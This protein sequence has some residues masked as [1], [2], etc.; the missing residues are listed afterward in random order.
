[1]EPVKSVVKTE[2]VFTAPDGIEHRQGFAAVTKNEAGEEISRSDI[3][4]PDQVMELATQFKADN[5]TF[6]EMR[7]E[8]TSVFTYQV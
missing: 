7:I 3:T 6:R 5:P 4:D 1:M 8:M 2:L